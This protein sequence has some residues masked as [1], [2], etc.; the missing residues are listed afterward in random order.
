MGFARPVATVLLLAL[1]CAPPAD[2]AQLTETDVFVGEAILAIADKRYDEAMA[3][4]QRALAGEPQHVEALYYTGVVHMARREPQQAVPFLERARAVSPRDL[5]IAFQLGVAYFA[6]EDYD[7]AA[8]L[9]E[10]AFAAEPT[11]DGL[12]YYTGFVRYQRGDHQGALRAFRAGRTSD[13]DLAQLTRFYTGLAL[14]SMGLHGQA[15]AEVEQA[16]RLQPASPLSGPA[17][18]LRDV[19]VSA[20]A[21]D[22]RFR[23]EARFGFFYDDN[24]VV[25]P[26]EHASDF[27]VNDLRRAKYESS[28]ELFSLRL[29]Y[30]WLRVADW[31][32]N[33]S[34]SFFTTYN[35]DLP[36]LNL[37]DHVAA[38]GVSRRDVVASMPLLSG[39]Q[40]SWD[41]LM[42]DSKEFL[43]RFGTLFYAS[44]V[45]SE[46]HVTT[47]F[48]R[49]EVKEYTETRPHP[50]EEF[51]DAINWM[52]GLQHMARFN[53]GRHYVKAGYQV[54]FDDTRGRD[55]EYLGHKFLA[56]F[57]ATLPWQE[58]RLIYDFAMH[59]R[60]YRF[61]HA[62]LPL[63]DPDTRAR[64]DHDMV[65][66]VRFEW[67]VP[68][69]KN[70][71]AILDFQATHVR[72]N[73]AEF[74]YHRR[75]GTLALVWAF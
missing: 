62:F 38:V 33:V 24:A 37:I 65:N 45:E 4:L 41:V 15:S 8:P 16:L 35:N 47:A 11:L 20:R 75:V 40:F 52:F 5:A 57:Q 22:R 56:G 17:E 6:A 66:Q 12:G 49:N 44:L 60:K 74:T 26:Q 2:A 29:E 19:L 70:L 23:G 36:S 14:A 42:L 48:F 30:D 46:R 53:E 73:F 43:Q 69:G 28:G 25:R 54:D 1:L 34:Y 21:R 63:D 18:R 13:P 61:K 71:T 10:Q 7:R 39:W 67:P 58:I 59:H 68:W 51:Q 50:A 55:F 64:D 27:L 72:S 3:S 9:L 31:T 32:F